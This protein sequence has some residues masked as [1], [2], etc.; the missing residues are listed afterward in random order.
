MGYC[1]NF[2]QEK[3]NDKVVGRRR[4]QGTGHRAEDARRKDPLPGGVGVGF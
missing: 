4:A 2:V 3:G 1:F